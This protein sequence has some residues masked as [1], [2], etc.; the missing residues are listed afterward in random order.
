MAGLI[1]QNF[2]DDLLDRTDIV[3]LIDSRISLRKSGRNYSALC[4]FH[5]EKSPSFSVS[6]DKQFYYCFGCG[7]GGNAIGFVMEFEHLDFRA[8]VEELARKSGLEVPQESQPANPEQQKKQK[9]LYQQLD[10]ATH[11][12]QQQLRGHPQRQIAVDYLKKRGLTGEVAKS[13]AIG[14][15]PP[16]WH[17]LE[18]A[19]ISSEEDKK[20]LIDAGLLITKDQSEDTYD[21]FRERIVFPIRDS[22][23]RTIAFGG[24]VLGND[25][26]KYL[27]SPETQVFHK[28]RELYG[29]YEARQASNRLTRFI[30]VEGYMDVISLAQFDIHNAVATLGTATS[31]EHLIKLFRTVS[32]VVFCFDGDAAGRQAAERALENA[33][34]CM[35]DGRQIRFMF[36]PEGEDPDTLVRKEG[37]VGFDK[38]I[39]LAKSLPDF[40]FDCLLQQIDTSSLDGK[41]RLSKLALKKMQSLPNGMLRQLM[42]EQLASLTS[43]SVSQLEHFSER[44]PKQ[45]ND[46]YDSPL[47]QYA[48]EDTQNRPTPQRRRSNQQRVLSP[49]EQAIALLLHLPTLAKIISDEQLHE[50]E[51]PDS[52]LLLDLVKLLKESPSITTGGIIGHWQGVDDQEGYREIARLSAIE[53]PV[54]NEQHLTDKFS[55]VLEL[56]IKQRQDQQLNKLLEKSI[57][58][59]L[60]ADEKAKLAQLLNQSQSRATK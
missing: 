50:L 60:T 30:I 54:S 10:R 6:P 11:Y 39:T 21:R 42:I 14:F 49:V 12:Y 29:L 26:P 23:G 51:I 43:L 16:G 20:Q 31:K 32:E 5:K 25:K 15:A 19:L 47:E 22:R 55:G 18:N 38:Q 27:N 40:F 17:N 33:L 58:S 44:T 8:A 53:L 52:R 3:E 36:L 1:P 37:K 13:F 4:P 56:L 48:A 34:P 41:A 35:E 59:E 28:G 2:I 7:A 9:S 46:D 24:R 57:I 45:T